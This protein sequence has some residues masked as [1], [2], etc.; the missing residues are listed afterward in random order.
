M[1]LRNWE[2]IDVSPDGR[3]RH[4]AYRLTRNGA[5][6]LAAV[7]NAFSP[8]SRDGYRADVRRRQW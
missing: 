8:G 3:I 7:I 1:R 5:R 2:V 4:I 6:W